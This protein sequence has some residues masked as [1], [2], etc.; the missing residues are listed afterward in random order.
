[1]SYIDICDNALV[2][3]KLS[4]Q[5]DV[6]YD[7]CVTLFDESL[8]SYQDVAVTIYENPRYFYSGSTM[9]FNEDKKSICNNKISIYYDGELS[10]TYGVNQ[11]STGRFSE[12]GCIYLNNFI[13]YERSPVFN[14]YWILERP[15]YDFLSDEDVTFLDHVDADTMNVDV[16]QLFKEE[17]TTT[18]WL[19]SEKMYRPRKITVSNSTKRESMLIEYSY[20]Y[21]VFVPTKIEGD[22][23]YHSTG[24]KQWYTYT[25]NYDSVNKQV[26]DNYFTIPFDDGM[27]I[28]NWTTGEG[29]NTIYE[30]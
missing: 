5:R 17:D 16:F 8:C 21:N 11:L 25:I 15:V 24:V 22:V 9:Y 19:S 26:D 4:Y 1:M 2:S 28:T 14:H 20:I 12:V 6:Y 13:G 3:Y 29:E 27:R 23:Y 30:K 10:Y 7:S 18:V